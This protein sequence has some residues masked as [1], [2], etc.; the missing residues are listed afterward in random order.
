MRC[1]EMKGTFSDWLWNLAVVAPQ[2]DKNRHSAK[3]E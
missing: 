2:T 3:R 1:E